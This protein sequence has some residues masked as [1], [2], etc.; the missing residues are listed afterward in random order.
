MF[1]TCGRGY[2]VVAVLG[3]GQEPTNHAL[4]DIAALSGEFEK[5]G[6][7]MVLLFPSEEQYKKFRPSEFPGLPSTITY[8]I[9]VDGAIQK[10][11][12]DGAVWQLHRFGNLFLDRSIYVDTIGNG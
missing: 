4:R 5:W 12:Q 1:Q 10:H 11:G 8:G 6:R 7:K 3:A 2:Y 9:D